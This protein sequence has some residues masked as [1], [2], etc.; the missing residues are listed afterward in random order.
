MTAMKA[1]YAGL[2]SLAVILVASPAAAFPA[3]IVI[4][5]VLATTAVGVSATQQPYET[6]QYTAK[7]GWVGGA[8]GDVATVEHPLSSQSG[9]SPRIVSACREALTRLAQPH[10]VASME[11]V[12]KGKPKRVNGRTIAPLDVRAIYRVRGVHE[13]TRS[14]VRCEIDRA[15]RVIAT[16]DAEPASRFAQR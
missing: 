2:L 5:A 16:A 11:V 15:G 10:D 12:G 9:T 6:W 8:R 13:V 4:G 1:S 3:A 14:T 7:Y